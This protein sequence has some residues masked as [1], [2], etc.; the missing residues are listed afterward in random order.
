MALNSAPRS[1]HSPDVVKME[2]SF[3]SELVPYSGII[4]LVCL[5]VIFLVRFWVFEGFLLEK[6]YGKKYTEMSEVVLRGFVN[7][8]VAGSIKIVLMATAIYP[9]I[10]VASG[11]S[12]LQTPM[13]PG[14]LVTMGD[15]MVVCSQLFIGMYVFELFYRTKI[16]PIGILHHIGAMLIAQS[17]VTISMDAS[18]EEDARIEFMLCF[19]WG[20]FDVIA[21]FMPHVTII[22]YR[23]YPNHHRFLARMFKVSCFT[24]LASTTIET[25]IVMWL[26]GSLWD[27]WTIAFKVSTPILH[28]LFS[29]AQVWGALVFR[30]MWK[31]QERLMAEK[32]AETDSK[33][34]A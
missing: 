32:K 27:K 8:H 17:A 11:H 7:H 33:L 4:L 14:S 26:F 18:H 25:A 24:E 12:S 29:A 28:V 23:V 30:H 19:V 20:A 34:W 6:V 22:L 13:S 1:L 16:S 31:N 5:V 10:S 2:Q 15:M 21:E 3:V 9:L